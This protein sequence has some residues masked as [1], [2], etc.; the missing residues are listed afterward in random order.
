[1]SL[2][3]PQEIRA[4]AFTG[5]DFLKWGKAGQDS[6]FQ[7]AMDMASAISG[8]NNKDAASCLGQWYYKSDA[9][10]SKRNNL[11]RRKISEN[12]GYHPTTV[13]LALIYKECG[14]F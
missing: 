11:F 9:T 10:R 7:T 13:M 8:Q 3:F 6:Y 2:V 14:K 1:M 12:P 5:Q 4:E